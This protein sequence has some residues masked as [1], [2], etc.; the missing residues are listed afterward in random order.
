MQDCLL[1]KLVGWEDGFVQN[2][3]VNNNKDFTQAVEKLPAESS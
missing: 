3:V 2:F 1:L